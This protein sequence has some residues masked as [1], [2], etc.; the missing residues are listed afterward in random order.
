M[1]KKE[2]NE[3]EKF[4]EQFFWDKKYWF[5]NL[6]FQNWY[7]YFFIIKEVSRFKPKIILE[8]GEGSGV[9]KNVL[10]DFTE[11]YRTMDVNKNL[12]PDFLSDIRKYKKELSGM[13]DCIIIADV[14]E[15]L[16]FKDLEQS[17]N[18]LFSY[19]GNN[20][21]VVVTIPHR[22]SHFLISTPARISPWAFRIPT[23]FLS[24]GSFYRRFIKKKIWIDPYHRWEI[25]DGVHE[26]KKVED[27][28]KKAGFKIE[29][30]QKL[31]YVDFWVL[32]KV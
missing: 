19:L 4:N 17:V 26:I 8:I 22:A 18:N 16:P 23:G 1:Q 14:L 32:A 2:K 25:G 9:V 30:F 13:F 11:E 28:F 12:N 15:H 21:K 6:D 27:I 24:M 20:G 5:D 3:N 7:R 29:K 10:E 31:V